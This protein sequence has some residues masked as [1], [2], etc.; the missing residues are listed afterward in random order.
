MPRNLAEP[1]ASAR[2]AGA[3]SAN[4]KPT[5]DLVRGGREAAQGRSTSGRSAEDSA[6]FAG[7]TS[8]AMRVLH[9]T[10][11]FPWPATSGGSV[12]TLS[13]LRI[14]GSLPEVDSVSLLSVA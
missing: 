14:I 7:R 2:Q 3:D 5:A 1:G 12:R 9:L 10:T 4:A 8:R 6:I 11:E 13:Q